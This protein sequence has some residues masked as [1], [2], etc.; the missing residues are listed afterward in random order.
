V[1]QAV[2]TGANWLRRLADYLVGI[3]DRSDDLMVANHDIRHFRVAFRFNE[4]NDRLVRFW[5]GNRQSSRPEPKGSQC[6][7]IAPEPAAQPAAE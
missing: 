3:E 7:R 2:E 5:Y 1:H 4:L 6:P